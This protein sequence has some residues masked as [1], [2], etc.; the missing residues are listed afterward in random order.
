MSIERYSD[1]IP[2][3]PRFLETVRRPEPT[4]LRVRVG[5]IGLEELA[6]RLS[7]QGFRTR[8]VPGLPK[9]LEVV[10]GPRPVSQTREHWQG[11]FYRQQTV[12]GVAAPVLG[13]RPGERVLDMCA[14]PGGKTTHL[15]ELMAERGCLVA[16]DVS[17]GRLKGLMGNLTR[18]LIPNVV[19]VTAD[20][21]RFP[22]GALFD[23][24]LVDAP[25]SAEGNLRKKGGVPRGQK[26]SFLRHVTR[27]QERVLRRAIEVV[28]PGGTLL[29][30]TCTFAPEENEAVVTR[31]LEDSPVRVEPVELPVPSAPGLTRFEDVTYDRSLELAHRLYPH[32]FDS[33]G[34]FLVLLRKE[35]STSGPLS[36]WSPVPCS[37]PGDGRDPAEAVEWRRDGIERMAGG[38]GVDPEA[39]DGLEWMARGDSAWMHTC[40]EWPVD[41]WEPDEWRI[42]S[43]GL[44]GLSPG[45]R[46][47]ARPT[48]YL[49]RRLGDAVTARRVSLARSDAMT[50]LRREACAGPDLP[51]GHVALALDDLL[52]GRGSLGR[53]GIRHEIPKARAQRLLEILE[54][55]EV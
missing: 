3:W 7:R 13:A 36:G 44:R 21:R 8:T 34:L 55:E 47:E 29:Y 51:P 35:G 12:T 22:T 9:F 27:L 25:C 40:T 41:A 32:H 15:A 6:S 14:S 39:L 1:I 17:E 43:V 24:V 5:R 38:F 10:A 30:V 48:N 23:R 20:G 11:L 16:A 4:T 31:V 45:P 18:L 46:N 37:F 42:S 19:A 26:P 52:I 49:L 50:V 54:L 28:K 33:G 53:A 2:D